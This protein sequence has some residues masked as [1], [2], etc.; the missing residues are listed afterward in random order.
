MFLAD[1]KDSPLALNKLHQEIDQCEVSGVW[2]TCFLFSEAEY[3]TS[4][5]IAGEDGVEGGRWGCVYLAT[6]TPKFQG[7]L[8]FH[9]H[10]WRQ[11]L[12]HLDGGWIEK[13]AASE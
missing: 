9:R 13:W 8:S 6:I 12:P 4:S 10:G 11:R 5:S 1:D 7:C 3:H 2:G